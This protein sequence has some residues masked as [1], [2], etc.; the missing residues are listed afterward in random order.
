VVIMA[1]EKDIYI[2]DVIIVGAGPCMSS[3][4]YTPYIKLIVVN[5]WF[6]SGSPSSRRYSF[7]TFHRLRAPTLSLDAIIL[8]VPQNVQEFKSN[9]TSTYCPRP[10]AFWSFT[11]LSHIV[12][13]FLVTFWRGAFATTSF[14][15]RHSGA[16]C[17]Q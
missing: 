16:R 12:L 6:S 13:V 1:A 14:R 17:I 7:G 5:R 2:H 4:L 11:F 8:N 10:F 15:T 9:S 3:M